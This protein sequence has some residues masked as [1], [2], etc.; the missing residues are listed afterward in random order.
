MHPS[1]HILPNIGGEK[2]KL[3]QEKKLELVLRQLGIVPPTWSLFHMHVIYEVGECDL[4]NNSNEKFLSII[5]YNMQ[6]FPKLSL[7]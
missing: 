3:A 7:N 4:S 1:S 2:I 6:V 5:W